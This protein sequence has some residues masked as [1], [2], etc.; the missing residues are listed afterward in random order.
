ML[1]HHRARDGSGWSPRSS[2]S[3]GWSMHGAHSGCA[4]SRSRAWISG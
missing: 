4:W 1:E 3:N 2:R